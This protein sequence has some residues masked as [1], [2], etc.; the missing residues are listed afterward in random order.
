MLWSKNINSFSDYNID[1]NMLNSW[2]ASFGYWDRNPGSNSIST[3][4]AAVD[5]IE[6]NLY[7]FSDVISAGIPDVG[8]LITDNILQLLIFPLLLPSL[9]IEAVN[10]SNFLSSLFI[11]FPACKFTHTHTQRLALISFLAHLFVV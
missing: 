10:V 4:L 2:K 9:R 1:H 11:S 3:I 8:K 7:Y 6:D 5:E